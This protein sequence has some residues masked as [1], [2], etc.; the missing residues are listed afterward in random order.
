M[1]SVS[2]TKRGSK[3]SD[4]IA[5]PLRSTCYHVHPISLPHPFSVVC[6]YQVSPLNLNLCFKS[7]ATCS[8]QAEYWYTYMCFIQ[9]A[10]IATVTCQKHM[11]VQLDCKKFKMKKN[12]LYLYRK[13]TR[14]ARLAFTMISAPDLCVIP[15]IDL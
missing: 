11:Y 3:G 15:R 7:L 4:V 10:V 8:N 2:V 13:R 9:V 6:W 5:P 1:C 12:K 14:F